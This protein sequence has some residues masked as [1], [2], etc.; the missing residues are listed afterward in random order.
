MQRLHGEGRETTVKMSTANY[1][2]LR[3]RAHRERKSQA[4]VLNEVLDAA[5]EGEEQVRLSAEAIALGSIGGLVYEVERRMRADR[6][7]K[8]GGG[9]G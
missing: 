8:E 2:W 3:E 6:K 5:R 4:L 7:A 9:D 1:E